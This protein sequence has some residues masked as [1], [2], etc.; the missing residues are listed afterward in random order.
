M[1]PGRETERYLAARELELRTLG[2]LSVGLLAVAAYLFDKWTVRVLGVALG[3]PNLLLVVGLVASANRQARSLALK[4]DLLLVVGARRLGQLLVSVH[5]FMRFS[6][7]L[8]GL[9]L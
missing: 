1:S 7:R 9:N 5:L 3:T 8:L 2:G 4:P 6:F